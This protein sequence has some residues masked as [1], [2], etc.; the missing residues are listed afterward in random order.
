MRFIII[1]LTPFILFADTLESAFA[2][3]STTGN[4]TFYHL[5]QDKGGELSDAR[6]NA[7]GGDLQFKTDSSKKLFAT[8]GFHNSSPVFDY[9]NKAA[10]GLFNNDKKAKALSVISEAHITYKTKNTLLKAGDFLLNTPLINSTSAR[11]VPWSYQGV[12]FVI[13]DVF[14]SSLQLNYINRIRKY[15]TDK[16]TKQ[17][18][19]GKFEKPITM[20]GFK[21][22]PIDQLD[23]HIYYYNAPDL[24]DSTFVQID[25]KDTLTSDNILFCIGAQNIKAYDDQDVNFLGLRTGIFTEHLDMTLNYSKNN[26]IDGTKAYGGLS[27]VY[28][29][30]MISNGRGTDKPETWML[31][32]NLS[33]EPI[34]KH[35]T[36]FAIWLADIKSDN[37]EY[38]SYYAHIKHTTNY[39]AKLYIRYEYKDFEDDRL[40]EKYFRFIASYDF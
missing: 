2:K 22:H 10:T 29:S 20:I 27:K 5:E 36:E 30:S 35:N 7:I 16:Y 19:M 33:F 40:D 4:I 9:K 38:K 17:S 39:Y 21:H 15:T 12:S 37:S 31:K 6:A 25:Y 24:Y 18:K 32:T 34:N 11:I 26:G 1:L 28:T 13:S 23:V 3:A 8:L 14:K